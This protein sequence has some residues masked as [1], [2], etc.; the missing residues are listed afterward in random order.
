MGE[1]VTAAERLGRVLDA[2]SSMSADLALEG[3]PDRVL[4]R[5]GQMIDAEQGYFDVL[6]PRIGPS[7]AYG[8]EGV[9]EAGRLDRRLLVDL[10][11]R[12]DAPNEPDIASRV[13][14]APFVGVPVTIGDHVFGH[15][16]LAGRSA[17]VGFSREDEEIA[18]TLAAAAAVVIENARLYE[19]GQRQ[20]RWLDAA[21]DIT[22]ALLSPISRSTGLQ[23]V[24]DR[25]RDVADADFVSLL[26]PVDEEVL[27][28]EAVSGVSADGVLGERIDARSSLAGAAA[29]LGQTIV[30]P[31]TDLEPRYERRMAPAWPDLGALMVL[32][33]RS[34]DET[35][36]LL[37]G[38][39][40]GH[41]TLGGVFD[42]E[43]AQRFADQAALV[44]QVARAQEDQAR[45]AVFVDRDRIGR[46]LH[47]L[48]IQRLF[49]IGLVLD[50]TTKLIGSTPAADRLSAAIDDID[51]TIKDI[52]RTIF[53]LSPPAESSDLRAELE[54][55]MVHS[56]ELLGFSPGLRMSGPVDSVITDTIRAHLVAVLGEAMSNI[57]RHAKAG[58]VTVELD[59]RKAI[60]LVVRDDGAGLE[61]QQVGNGLR[62]IRDRAALLGGRCTVD[63]RVG[64]GTTITWTVP[65]SAT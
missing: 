61:P 21:A 65:R 26:T 43:V 27:V 1:R 20:R 8:I 30:V 22:T 33:L 59:V 51:H 2:V 24:A 13:E 29:R 39:L 23:L 55:I 6:D 11:A 45:L 12:A 50:N 41:D 64:A 53:A 9:A 3:L 10:L 17:G 25:A 40:K 58:S 16:Y 5:T 57:V 38:W 47:D 35:G 52:R 60:C 56:S 46:D 63:S 14:R 31:D 37:V 7:A 18:R 28:V 44:L 36:A 62:N 48:V 15:I 19:V 49:G 54:Q 42:S 32:P 34:G 4:R